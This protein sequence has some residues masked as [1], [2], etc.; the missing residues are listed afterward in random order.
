M[1]DA[2]GSEPCESNLVGVRVSPTAPS[3]A[4]QID[5]SYQDLK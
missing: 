4:I 5:A 1:V 3:L 2:H